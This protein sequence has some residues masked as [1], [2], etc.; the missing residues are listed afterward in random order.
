MDSTLVLGAFRI[1]RGAGGEAV[2]EREPR[3]AG[4]GRLVWNRNYCVLID[5]QRN[6]NVLMACGQQEVKG[7]TTTQVCVWLLDRPSEAKASTHWDNVSK[8]F[9]HSI[10]GANRSGER[11]HRL[12]SA[13]Q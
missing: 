1:A 13:D 12:K 5:V 11:S 4:E 10:R 8:P 7:G 9:W 6:K 3:R 2:R